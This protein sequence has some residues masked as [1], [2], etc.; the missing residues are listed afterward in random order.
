MAKDVGNAHIYPIRI[1]IYIHAHADTCTRRFPSRKYF[2]RDT[3]RRIHGVTRRFMQNI[4]RQNRASPEEEGG[5]HPSSVKVLSSLEEERGGGGGMDQLR[6]IHSRCL[7][8]HVIFSS[9]RWR[10]RT[11]RVVSLGDGTLEIF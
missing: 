5:E 9:S 2:N 8:V 7:A 6:P 11:R 3:I 1:Y 10:S 4:E